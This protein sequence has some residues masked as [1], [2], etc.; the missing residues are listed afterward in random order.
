MPRPA[1]ASAKTSTWSK[2]D[3]ARTNP[4]V[5]SEDPLNEKASNPVLPPSDQ[6][7]RVN[8]MATVNAQ[9]KGSRTR[10]TGA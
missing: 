9:A 7:M 8:P 1:V 6:N 3:S 5:S 4:R 10:L 2:T